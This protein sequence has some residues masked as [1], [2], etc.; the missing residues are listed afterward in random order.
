ML[1]IMTFC[2]LGLCAGAFLAYAGNKLNQMW[3]SAIIALSTGVII[4]VIFTDFLPE[5]VEIGGVLW[6]A[7]GAVI[8]YL[9]GYT[10]DRRFHS[11]KHIHQEENNSFMRSGMLIGASIALHN[12]PAGLLLG[13]T[14]IHLPH[15]GRE[16]GMVMFFHNVPEGLAMGVPLVMAK[17]RPANVMMLV[18]LVSAPFA[19][20]AVLGALVDVKEV[21]L[22]A[23]MI[24]LASGTIL[25]VSW[26]EVFLKSLRGIY[27]SVAFL[28]FILGYYASVILL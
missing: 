5:A 8:G 26:F 15:L 22:L 16:L 14:F 11:H 18:L 23:L 4:G 10:F 2:S 19:I 1:G 17:V 28:L 25:Y 27:V 21:G 20:G 13:N 12:F 7:A 6:A 24:G 3:L 9:V